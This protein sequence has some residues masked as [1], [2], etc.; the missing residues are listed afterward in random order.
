MIASAIAIGHSF[1]VNRYEEALRHIYGIAH[2]IKTP[3][4]KKIQDII[5]SAYNG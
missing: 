4:G 3:D 5:E 1:K 2:S